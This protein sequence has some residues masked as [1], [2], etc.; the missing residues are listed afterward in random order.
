MEI[1]IQVLKNV[2]Q[3]V[4]CSQTVVRAQKVGKTDISAIEDLLKYGT[5]SHKI[6][7]RN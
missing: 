5:T 6:P 4:N 2:F 3:N 7:L 1:V